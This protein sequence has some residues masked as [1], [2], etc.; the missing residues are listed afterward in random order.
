M[1]VGAR[2]SVV[3]PQGTRTYSAW[4]PGMQEGEAELPLSEERDVNI[5]GFFD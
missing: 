5:G 2:T 3:S 1:L 4:P